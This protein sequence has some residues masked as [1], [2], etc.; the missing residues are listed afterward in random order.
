MWLLW[1]AGAQAKV[2]E[3]APAAV[4]VTPEGL[5]IVASPAKEGVSLLLDVP[6]GMHVYGRKE[7]L[8][9][10]LSVWIGGAQVEAVIP[11]GERVVQG[12][13]YPPAYWLDGLVTVLVP[14]R[15][16]AGELLVQACTE[17]TCYPPERLP[18]S[19]TPAAPPL[20]ANESPR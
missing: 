11:D 14:T 13:D 5:A 6:C 12:P 9:T 10:P 17:N 1:I 8:A 18:W 15:A 4:P 7:Q 19:V 3:G 2:C 20:R 16:T